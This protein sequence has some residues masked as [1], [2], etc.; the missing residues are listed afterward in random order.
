[1]QICAQID[2]NDRSAVACINQEDLVKAL[3][4]SDLSAEKIDSWFV[5][6][7][8]KLNLSRHQA[9]VIDQAYRAHGRDLI[10][11]PN[12]V[13]RDELATPSPLSIQSVTEPLPVMPNVMMITHPRN[14]YRDSD[15]DEPHWDPGCNTEVDL[16]YGREA[17]F[18]SVVRNACRGFK[19]V[20]SCREC[21]RAKKTFEMD[22]TGTYEKN[23]VHFLHGVPFSG[24]FCELTSGIALLV[25]SYDAEECMSDH[26]ETTYFDSFSSKFSNA[27]AYHIDKNQWKQYAGVR[28]R[29]YD[30]NVHLRMLQ[31]ANEKN[32]CMISKNNP[33]Y[34]ELPTEVLLRVAYDRYVCDIKDYRVID[35]YPAPPRRNRVHK[36]TVPVIGRIYFDHAQGEWY[37]AQGDG[38]KIWLRRTTLA[39][40]APAY[41]PFTA[42][43]GRSIGWHNG[44]KVMAWGHYS[45]APV[46]ALFVIHEPWLSK[47]NHQVLVSQ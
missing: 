1:M 13:R 40:M 27:S 35:I 11:L 14:A 4:S 15:I 16:L 44:A 32:L 31:D 10:H 42:E 30:T 24:E 38:G 20:N 17:H 41:P 28:V 46:N 18:W 12:G 22:D 36:P 5:A 19:S 6:Q 26:C 2:A 25:V 9:L 21:C 7:R 39:F 43:F 29:Q 45:P 33:L 8:K 34:A 23:C 37:L 47:V 3:E